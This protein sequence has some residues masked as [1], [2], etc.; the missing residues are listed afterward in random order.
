LQKSK[1]ASLQI[2]RENTK[3]ETIADSYNL[4]RVTEVACEFSV[5]RW[6]PSHLCT[7]TAPVA[8]RIFDHQCKTSF[9][10]QS[11][12]GFNRSTQH[13]LLLPDGEVWGECTD[14]VHAEAEGQTEVV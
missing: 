13:L 12:G 7:K 11:G 10:T 8:R 6:G 3:R 2:F 1:V 9:A 4:Y 5:R 14:T